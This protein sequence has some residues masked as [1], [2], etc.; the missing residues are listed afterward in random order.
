MFNFNLIYSNNIYPANSSPNQ[1][2]DTEKTV[3]V[4]AL[5]GMLNAEGLARI[6]NDLFGGVL[7]A[8]LDTDKYKYPMASGRVTFDNNRSCM[9]AL[10][11]AFIEIK[12][13]K[14]TKKVQVNSLC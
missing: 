6:M 13:P 7:H 12:T 4:G 5:H 1:R 3:F 11:A 8:G 10:A 14:F 2:L 9:E